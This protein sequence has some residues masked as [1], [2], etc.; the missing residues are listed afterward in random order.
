MIA[1]DIS[2]KYKYRENSYYKIVEYIYSVISAKNGNYMVF[3]PSYKYMEQVSTMFA[4][5]YAHIKVKIQTNLWVKMI[6]KLFC[7]NFS[8]IES[9]N[10]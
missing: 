1:K 3:F 8:D 7:K 9:E 10:I 5:K 6:G 2:T 4:L